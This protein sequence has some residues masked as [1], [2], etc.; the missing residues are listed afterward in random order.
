[1][2]KNQEI[3]RLFKLFKQESE[4]KEPDALQF[5]KWMRDR[6]W[7]VPVP[8]DP[9]DLLAK[10][11]KDAI[12]EEVRRDN[13]TGQPYKAILTF[14]TESGQ[15]T[16]WKLVDVDEAPR[17]TVYKCLFQRR[18]QTVGD[19]YQ[20]QLIED[21]WNNIHPD[22]EPIRMQTDYGPDMEWKK[23]GPSESAA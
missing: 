8:P 4:N 13:K 18:E 11:L 7:K 2:T 22:E 15:G 23:N 3:Q 10:Q 1:M 5:A 21:H 20:M 6:G 9:M 14:S 12:C 19:I 16:F 17:K